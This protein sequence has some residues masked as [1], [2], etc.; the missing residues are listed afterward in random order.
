MLRDNAHELQVFASAAAFDATV[1]ATR[2]LLQT[3]TASVTI[4]DVQR[5]AGKL[6]IPVRIENLTGHKFPTGFPSRRAWVRLEV[7]DADDRVIFISGGF[8]KL[9]RIVD[10]EG[11]VLA[12]EL[13]GG[14]SQPHH[15]H[16]A[17]SNEVQIYESVMADKDGGET[18]TLL[19]G[20]G[21]AKDNRLLPKGWQADHADAAAIA[22]VGVGS[23][24]DFRSGVDVIWYEVAVD[25]PGPVTMQA[26]LHYQSIGVRHVG[27]VFTFDTPEVKSFRSM[28]EAA[29]RL[30]EII[31]Q[32]RKVVDGG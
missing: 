27:E 2:K 12:S 25:S 26:S 14:P 6:R 13:A 23:D 19:R 16:V 7:R 3:E 5:L 11:Q 17:T 20:A 21:Y 1:A 28:Y 29:D 22:P 18:F 31:G 15:V 24:E 30:P 8:D 10:A 4:G 9:G 32:S